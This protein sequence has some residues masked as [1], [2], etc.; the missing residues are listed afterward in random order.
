MIKGREVLPAEREPEFKILSFTF[1]ISEEMEGMM[2][3]R[4]IVPKTVVIKKTKQKKTCTRCGL[5]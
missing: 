1:G 3:I 2:N 5:V 4:V